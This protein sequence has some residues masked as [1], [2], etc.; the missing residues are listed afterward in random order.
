MNR[1]S[2]VRLGIFV[3]AVLFVLCLRIFFAPYVTLALS[4]VDSA[5]DLLIKSYTV[6][7]AAG[8][9]VGAMVAKRILSGALLGYICILLAE[10]IGY[11]GWG[12]VTSSVIGDFFLSLHN[13]IFTYSLLG[14]V[15]GTLGALLVRKHYAR[16]K[17]WLTF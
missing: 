3:S 11:I 1:E 12:Y 4:P 2:Y 7:I 15:G 13:L 17:A 8:F 9:I 5:Y 6:P 10:Y 16:T 14:A